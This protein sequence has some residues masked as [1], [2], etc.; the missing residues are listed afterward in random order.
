MAG[1]VRSTAPT[2]TGPN[3]PAFLDDL[4][5]RYV[6]GRKTWV[7]VD[8]FEY[9]TD[10]V[11]PGFP[12]GIIYVPPGFETDFASVPRLF[13]NILPPTGPYGKPAVI[14]DLL[15]RTKGLATKAQADRI[16]LEAMTAQGVGWLTRQTIYRAVHY[17]GGAAYKGGL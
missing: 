17:F 13:W 15:Y 12:S 10:I 11:T 3:D 6:D 7:V 2:P 5:L 14:H 9:H 1:I 8:P 16:L 4:I